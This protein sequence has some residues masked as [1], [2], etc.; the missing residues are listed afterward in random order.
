MVFHVNL[1][2]PQ[3]RPGSPPASSRPQTWDS[4]SYRP[5]RR[6]VG[7]SNSFTFYCVVQFSLCRSQWN[8]CAKASR[9][10]LV[11]QYCLA[12]LIAFCKS[13]FV[14]RI[15]TVI[16]HGYELIVIR[17]ALL[18][19]RVN[20]WGSIAEKSWLARATVL[21]NA[22]ECCSNCT[23]RGTEGS[24]WLS[25]VLLTLCYCVLHVLRHCGGTGASKRCVLQ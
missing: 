5:Q 15:G 21:G 12:I 18:F 19:S 11:L 2:V 16:H 22:V 14:D 4:K 3:F 8:G 17:F 6:H 9:R 1:L 13:R 10:V 23:R 7:S 24:R 25:L 20:G